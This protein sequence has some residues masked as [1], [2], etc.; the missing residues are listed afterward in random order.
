VVSGVLGVAMVASINIGV[1]HVLPIYLGLAL[2]AGVGWNW[3]WDRWTSRTARAML[4]AG[5]AFLSIGSATIHPDY[6][7]Y[8]NVLAGREPS[9]IVA[10]SDLDWG[11]DMFRL[12]REVKR[13]NVDSLTFAYIGTSDISPIVGV[14]VR[15]WDGEGR[16]NGWVAVSETWYRRGQVAFRRGAYEMRPNAM[17]WLD[18]AATFTRV[19]KGIR[20]YHIAATRPA[21]EGPPRD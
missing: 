21:V 9:R 13:R 5:T 8:F 4:I 15:Y 3:A 7:A 11:Q 10:D 16:P 18:S 12:A 19:G 17:F 14:P 20:L 2:G 1:R 6:L